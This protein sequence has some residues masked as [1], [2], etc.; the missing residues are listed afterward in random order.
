MSEV[1]VPGEFV[2]RRGLTV[3]AAQVYEVPDGYV[4]IV[5]AHPRLSAEASAK[6]REYMSIGY[7]PLKEDPKTGP[8][9]IGATSDASKAKASG[10]T[11]KGPRVFI[12]AYELDNTGS[13]CLPGKREI[14]MIARKA[15]VERFR[16][17]WAEESSAYLNRALGIP[18][19][20][21]TPGFA[22]AV[23]DATPEMSD[24]VRAEIAAQ[25][26]EKERTVSKKGT[27]GGK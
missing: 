2:K 6:Y 4:A 17:L 13:V 5:L 14:V 11:V 7:Q 19:G 22:G 25:A 12:P 24:A 27:G 26:E 16:Q 3:E 23:A 20:E 18:E 10:G 8:F 21:D 15:V 9:G 1:H